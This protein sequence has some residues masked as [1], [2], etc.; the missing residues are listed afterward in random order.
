MLDDDFD[1]PIAERVKKIVERAKREAEEKKS[2]PEVP[3]EDRI[4]AIVEKVSK[5]EDN[6]ASP[7]KEEATSLGKLPTPLHCRDASDDKT[8]IVPIGD[9]LVDERW[10]VR[11]VIDPT[12]S[13]NVAL[14]ASIADQGLIEPLTVWVN[15]EHPDKLSLVAGFRRFSALKANG[16]KHVRV[17]VMVNATA[18]DADFVNVTENVARV[19][20]QPW[21]IAVRCARYKSQYQISDTQIAKRIGLSS[22]RV[23]TL[24]RLETKLHPRLLKVFHGEQATE[25]STTE[26]E[27]IRLVK[28]PPLQQITLWQQ[29]R[30]DKRFAQM[31]ES[32]GGERPGRKSHTIGLVKILSV[33]KLERALLEMPAVVRIR[34]IKRKIT[35]TERLAATQAL[36]W[37][38]GLSTCPFETKLVR[39]DDDPYGISGVDE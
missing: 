4:E 11:G 20:L 38:M 32:S 3:T 12:T 22:S 8:I 30:V 35:E 27:L 17:T 24:I 16:S 37:V 26:D 29:T 5:R 25:G 31:G 34:G 36:R 15:P 2:A 28:H 33:R 9:V 39:D 23:S 10:N 6:P 14:A 21:Q 1:L 7:R 19:N 13:E 18:L